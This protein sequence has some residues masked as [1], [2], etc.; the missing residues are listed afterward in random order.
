[1]IS[2]VTEISVTEISKGVKCLIILRF[3]YAYRKMIW[4]LVTLHLILNYDEN[5]SS[6]SHVIVKIIVVTEIYVDL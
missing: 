6:H 2:Q 3:F 4:T 5:K 1:M